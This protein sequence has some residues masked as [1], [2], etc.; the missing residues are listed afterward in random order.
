VSDTLPILL[1]Y[2]PFFKVLPNY[3]KESPVLTD[4]SATVNKVHF[5]LPCVT[6]KESCAREAPDM[7]SAWCK[8]LLCP[9]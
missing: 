8:Q 9:H 5:L 4:L 6:L 1:N 2:E 7:R 3:V